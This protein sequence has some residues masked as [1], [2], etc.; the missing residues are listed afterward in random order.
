MNQG[1]PQKK[2]KTIVKT[3]VSKKRRKT[4]VIDNRYDRKRDGR[5]NAVMV[6]HFGITA[7]LET[8]INALYLAMLKSPFHPAIEYPNLIPDTGIMFSMDQ[9][10]KYSLPPS[11]II[12]DV[13]PAEN[14]AEDED[15][16]VIVIAVSTR[17][18]GWVWHDDKHGEIPD[19]WEVAQYCIDCINDDTHGL[20]RL[21]ANELDLKEVPY[22]GRLMR[23]L[24]ID[25]VGIT[26]EKCL[27][28]AITSP[29]N[30]LAT[31]VFT[32]AT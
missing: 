32:P 29:V 18:G 20:A 12:V 1:T 30:H 17:F 15:R 4:T 22:K 9:C 7:K 10:E 26:T 28:R 27:D 11:A 24:T 31:H 19:P 14:A 6:W 5:N 23:T 13:R 8:V 25:T 2:A 3:S 16:C 21:I